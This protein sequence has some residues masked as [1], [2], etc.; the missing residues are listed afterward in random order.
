MSNSRDIA[1]SAATINFIDTVTSNVQ[2]QLD[3][4]D[5]LPSQTGNSGEFLTTN[6]TVASWA[7]VE[8]LP[9][10]SGQAGKFLTTNG[11]AAAW[12]AVDVSSEITGTMPIANGGTGATSLTA[13]NVLLGNGTSAPQAVAP[14]TAGN[15]LTS[16]GSTWASTAPAGGLPAVGTS[17]NVL[18]SNG[19]AWTSAVSLPITISDNGVGGTD[20]LAIGG[21]PVSTNLA[22]SSTGVLI[23]GGKA[24]SNI[25]GAINGKPTII[26][27][28]AGQYNSPTGM[29]A[30]TLIGNAAGGYS[31]TSMTGVSNTGVGNMALNNLTSGGYNTALGDTA[32]ANNKVGSYNTAVGFYALAG[33]TGYTGGSYNVGIGH[34]A[35]ANSWAASNNINIG[36]NSHISS[37]TAS[38][39]TAIGS[40]MS[41][42]NAD[43]SVSLGTNAGYLYASNMGSA[44]WSA[45][46]DVRLKK[47]ISDDTLGLS[48]IN[49]LRTVTYN[50]KTVAELDPDFVSEGQTDRPAN[51]NHGLI[52]QEVKQAMDDAGCTTFNGWDEEPETGVQGISREIFVI[53]LIRAVNE[54]TAKVTAL[55]TEIQSIK[56]A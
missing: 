34:Q 18:T 44:S 9:T 3:N 37:I 1:D 41:G 8:A 51:T 20:Y 29:G 50:W 16:D 12:D 55:E 11:T 15:I 53:P 25:T 46:S 4:K 17:G 19:S 2:T 49:S 56:D 35:G 40:N 22:G 13:N 10:Q 28:Q 33:S 30:T 26:G 45:T 54:L 42:Y 47:N 36:G 48:F 39:R 14:S 32:L 38:Y 6:G 24:A 27:Y 23:I 43:Q 7:A 5:S 52:A 31:L 21:G